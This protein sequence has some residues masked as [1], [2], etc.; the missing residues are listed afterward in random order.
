MNPFDDATIDEKSF[1]RKDLAGTD[2][3]ETSWAPVRTGWTDVDPP[4]VTGRFRVVGKQCF[5]QV[6]VVPG[7]SIATTAGTSYIAL[8]IQA[9]GFGGTV[10]MF[11]TTT[12]VAEGVGGIDVANSRAHLPSVSATGDTEII[13]FWY[14]V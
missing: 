14:E 10:T 9:K 8:P 2:R 7:T 5:G 4:T 12:K 1:A 11:N 13:T 3:W 6:K